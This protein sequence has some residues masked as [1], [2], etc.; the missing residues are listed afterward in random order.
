MSETLKKS[1]R[2]TI[3]KFLTLLTAFRR[4]QQSSNLFYSQLLSFES[5]HKRLH[6]ELQIFNY[7]MEKKKI[8]LKIIT[9]VENKY[10]NQNK[11]I[12][13]QS[14]NILI[15]NEKSSMNY[16]NFFKKSIAFT[17]FKENFKINTT[18]EEFVCFG[19]LIYLQHVD[20]ANNF[21]VIFDINL[22]II[23]VETGIDDLNILCYEKICNLPIDIQISTLNNILDIF[24]DILWRKCDK[25]LSYVDFDLNIPILRVPN[26]DFF[27]AYH[28]ICVNSVV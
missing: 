14:K 24:S 9:V 25:C 2:T 5:L 23:N 1:I 3:D 11:N 10:E 21:R 17:E 16:N 12:E 27:M 13:V 6:N 4:P 20:S 18:F 19:S 22:G 26:G 28:K 15:L 8:S 7:L